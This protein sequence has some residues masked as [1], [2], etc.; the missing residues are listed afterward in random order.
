MQ[1]LVEQIMNL[2]WGLVSPVL[3]DRLIHCQIIYGQYC[4]PSS[5]CIIHNGTL[6]HIKRP[7]FHHTTL[8]YV[9]HSFFQRLRHQLMLFSCIW[10]C[11]FKVKLHNC[12]NDFQLCIANPPPPLQTYRILNHVTILCLPMCAYT[13]NTDW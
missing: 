12:L 7:V 10:Q 9:S 2:L 4:N 8:T 1:S 3:W 6:A 13:C 5:K 11:C